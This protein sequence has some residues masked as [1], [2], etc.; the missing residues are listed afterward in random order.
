MKELE[1]TGK[2]RNLKRILIAVI[3]VI[4]LVCIWMRTINGPRY[5]GRSLA[6]W[7]DEINNAGSLSNAQPALEAIRAIGTNGLPFLLASIRHRDSKLKGKMIYFVE[8]ANITGITIPFRYSLTGAS[9]LALKALGTNA[10]PIAPEIG[11]LLEDPDRKGWALM[12]LFSIGSAAAPTLIKACESTNSSVRVDA[13]LYLSKVADGSQRSWSWGWNSN[14]SGR[15]KLF[16]VGS[17][18]NES[19]AAALATQ[20]K[21][22]D[23]A[24]RRASAEALA[25]HRR[26]AR[27]VVAGLKA[28]LKD[29]NQPVREAS[30]KAL[31]AIEEISLGKTEP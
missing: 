1:G 15:R 28:A 4:L 31:N 3:G 20:L 5:Q 16:G 21:H 30:Q 7:L 22:P 14:L 11:D 26:E 29:T 18:I 17:V 8:K 10:T 23:P 9:C 19:D 12:A 27:A 24:V 25:V 13:A 6:S 2:M